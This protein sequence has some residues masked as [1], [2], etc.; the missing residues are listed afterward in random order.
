[1]SYVKTVKLPLASEVQDNT[2]KNK[3]YISFDPES[4]EPAWVFY[5]GRRND[6]FGQNGSVAKWDPSWT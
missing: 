3:F 5:P 2:Q 1:M 4:Q 6:R